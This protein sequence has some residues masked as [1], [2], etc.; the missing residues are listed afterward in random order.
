MTATKN[1]PKKSSA[2]KAP[3]SAAAKKGPA[4]KATRPKAA[5]KKVSRKAKVNPAPEFTAQEG[6]LL[7]FEVLLY[8]GG[9]I[10]LSELRSILAEAGMSV[11]EIKRAVRR[12]TRPAG[13]VYLDRDFQV[14]AL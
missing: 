3:H 4:K 8:A 6:E 1:T 13:Q 10:F 14:L 5:R 11:A 7:C 9:A 12:F 2:K